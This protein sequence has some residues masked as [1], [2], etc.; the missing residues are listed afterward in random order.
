MPISSISK[1][2]QFTRKLATL[3]QILISIDKYQS[4][5]NKQTW[6]AQHLTQDNTV[7]RE[8]HILREYVLCDMKS[9]MQLPYSAL[10]NPSVPELTAQCDMQQTES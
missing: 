3:I 10:F 5:L 1:G 2:S 9:R 4:V 8:F 6:P 7:R